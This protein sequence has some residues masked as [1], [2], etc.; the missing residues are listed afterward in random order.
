MKTSLRLLVHSWR[1]L[2]LGA[3]L[4]ILVGCNIDM[5]T[6]GGRQLWSDIAWSDGWRVQQHV[7]TGHCRLLDAEETRREWGSEGSC[8]KA[9]PRGRAER[10]VILLHGLGRTRFSMEALR[11]KLE[12]DGHRVASLS[13]SS[14]RASI[15]EHAQQVERVLNRL[16]GVEQVSFVTH[17][18]GGRVALR[19]LE[20]EGAWMDQIEVEHLVQIAPPNGGSSLARQLAGVPF[21]QSLM[22]PSFLDVRYPAMERPPGEI[23]VG[24]I[25]GHFG[26]PHGWNPLLA[27]GNDGVVTLAETRPKFAH[28]FLQLEVA[29]TFIMESDEAL[30]A[31][32]A[33]LDGRGLLPDAAQP[34]F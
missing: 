10:L 30:A 5:P 13:Y 17:S 31:V 19:L 4:S 27:A 3:L 26:S 7:W 9:L 34:E 32:C 15:D 12:A 24:V 25:A 18:L 28:E 6:M 23:A 11:Q 2:F 14:T 20:R 21:V 22:G 29:H 33:F 1:S 8:Y 16:E